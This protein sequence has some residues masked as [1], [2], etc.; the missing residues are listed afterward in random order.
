MLCRLVE[1][2]SAIFGFPIVVKSVCKSH[3][4]PKP[5]FPPSQL[6]VRMLS[7]RMYIHD[8]VNNTIIAYNWT[9]IQLL[10]YNFSDVEYRQCCLIQTGTLG[11]YPYRRP[12]FLNIFLVWRS[13]FYSPHQL[14]A[15]LA[16]YH[17]AVFI[18]LIIY[19]I[20]LIYLEVYY[21]LPSALFLWW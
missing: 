20:F 8:G 11:N 5:F 7:T 15:R 19:L 4:S 13:L 10:Y 2:L 17:F 14:Y 6:S 9:C 12:S 16:F 3:P 18:F 1:V 21:L